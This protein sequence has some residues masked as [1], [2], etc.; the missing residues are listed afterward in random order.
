MSVADDIRQL[1]EKQ[2]APV[3]FDIVNESDKHAGHA[4]ANETGETH[5]RLTI[6]SERFSGL[7]PVARHRLVMTVLKPLLDGPV[8]ALALTTKTPAE[9]QRG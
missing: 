8:H 2:C 7:P 4:G 3:S 1:V 9:I 5:F 6:V